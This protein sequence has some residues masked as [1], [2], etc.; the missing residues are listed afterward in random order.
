MALHVEAHI[1]FLNVLYRYFVGSYLLIVTRVLG[2]IVYPVHERATIVVALPHRPGIPSIV[3]VTYFLITFLYEL[4][5]RSCKYHS[6][7]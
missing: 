2:F 3:V 5:S 1:F 7:S 4:T 6:M